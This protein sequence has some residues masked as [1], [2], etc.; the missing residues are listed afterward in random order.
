MIL[1]SIT[2]IEQFNSDLR[3]RIFGT[4][5]LRTTSNLRRLPRLP[6]LPRSPN[7]LLLF[8]R[9][10][11]TSFVCP[12][13]FEDIETNVSCLDIQTHQKLTHI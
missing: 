2:D 5:G 13:L 7:C 11:S 9:S 6:R 3:W 4:E 10:F 8:P 12:T 1:E